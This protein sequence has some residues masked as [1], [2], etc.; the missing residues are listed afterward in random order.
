MVKRDKVVNGL[1]E[2]R[3]TLFREHEVIGNADRY[4]LG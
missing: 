1:G 4:G 3:M 2:E